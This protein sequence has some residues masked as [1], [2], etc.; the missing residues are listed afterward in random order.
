MLLKITIRERAFVN[1]F[2][3]TWVTIKK[4]GPSRTFGSLFLA[5]TA[6]AYYFHEDSSRSYSYSQPTTTS[7]KYSFTIKYITYLVQASSG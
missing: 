3:A 7:C 1:P 4:S 5:I 6:H 2:P